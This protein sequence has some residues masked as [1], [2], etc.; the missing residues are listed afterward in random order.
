M[1]P[2]TSYIYLSLNFLIYKTKLRIDLLIVLMRGVNRR[3]NIYKGL[4]WCPRCSRGYASISSWY[5]R[6]LTSSPTTITSH[7]FRPQ[8]Q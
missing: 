5:F 4:E 7:T 6:S 8:L 3:V 1:W 2:W